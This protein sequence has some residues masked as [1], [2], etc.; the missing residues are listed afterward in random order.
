MWFL[1]YLACLW[2][3]GESPSG[4]SRGI[5]WE[6]DLLNQAQAFVDPIQF[7]YNSMR[8]VE[9]AC[10]TSLHLPMSH[11][12]SPDTH[13]RLWFV[14][15]SSAFNTIKPKGLTKLPSDFKTDFYLTEGVSEVWMAH[16]RFSSPGSPQGHVLSPLLYILYTSK[17]RSQH[18]NR[19]MLKFTSLVYEDKRGPVVEV[20]WWDEAHLRLYTLKPRTW[21]LVFRKSSRPLSQINIR[22][23]DIEMVEQYRY[24]RVVQ[25]HKLKFDAN[26]EVVTKSTIT[27]RI[28]SG[29][30]RFLTWRGNWWLFLMPFIESVLT[31]YIMVWFRNVTAKDST[32]VSKVVEVASKISAPLSPFQTLHSNEEYVRIPPG[33]LFLEVFGACCRTFYQH[34]LMWPGNTRDLSGW[35][36]LMSTGISGI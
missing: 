2:S 10:V 26:V 21:R 16:C 23:Q 32:N 1:T 20:P 36:V 22:G 35:T 33:C 13:T 4:R 3:R 28:F 5:I 29:S 25:D 24:L 27:A 31:F 17:C 19:K 6:A 7:A 30:C 11:L 34:C 12:E 9:D 8:G 18:E 14:D 15:F